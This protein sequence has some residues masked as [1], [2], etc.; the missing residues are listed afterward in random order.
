[1]SLLATVSLPAAF[2]FKR[3]F[4]GMGPNVAGQVLGFGEDLAALWAFPLL[5]LSTPCSSLAPDLNAA[6]ICHRGCT[7]VES[8]VKPDGGGASICGGEVAGLEPG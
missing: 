7:R 3:P 4:L 1:M 5:N 6:S 8:G 2:T